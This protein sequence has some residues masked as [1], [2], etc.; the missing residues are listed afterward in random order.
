MR[1]G[2]DIRKYSDFGIGTYIRNLLRDFDGRKEHEWIYFASPDQCA[3]LAKSY[4]GQLVPNRSGKYSF[5]ELLSMSRLANSADCQVFHSPHYTFPYGLKGRGVVTI[6]DL[7]HLR[8]H[9]LLSPPKRAYARFL[10]KHACKAADRII[11]VSEFTKQDIL[12]EFR[13][14]PDI[15]HV[16]YSG[17]SK[18]FCPANREEDGAAALERLGIRRPY[19]LYSGALKPHKNIPLLLRAFSQVSRSHDIDLVLTGEDLG[20]RPELAGLTRELGI[21]KR[22]VSTGRMSEGEVV[23]L[24]QHAQVAVLPSLY[25]GFGLPLLEAM[26]TATPVVAANATSIPEVVAE[27]GVLFD[28]HDAN[29]LARALDRVLTDARLRED[30]RAKGLRRAEAFTWERC[31]TKTLEVYNLAMVS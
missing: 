2:I 5:G 30:L 29:D 27:A 24:N 6:H 10:I 3:L 31:A 12:K 18:A 21:E 23:M 17:V 20:E 19:I 15:I 25:E 1:I 28:P 11:T 8:V 7:I 13:V 14:S 22:I 26:A 16:I 4:S 9:G